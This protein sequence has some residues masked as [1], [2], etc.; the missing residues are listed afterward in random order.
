MG[1]TYLISVFAKLGITF[2]LASIFVS[3]AWNIIASLIDLLC[4]NRSNALKHIRKHRAIANFNVLGENNLLDRLKSRAL[5]NQRLNEVFKINNSFTTMDQNIHEGFVISAKSVIHSMNPHKW[6]NF[7][8]VSEA[9]LDRACGALAAQTPL[10]LAAIARFVVFVA[11]LHQFF[12]AELTG[13]T[14]FADAVEATEAINNLWERSKDTQTARPGSDAE[15]ERLQASLK[16]LLPKCFPCPPEKHPLNI[17]LPAYETMWRVV[18]L[19][20][21]SAGFRDVHPETLQQF[22]EVIQ[23]VPRCFASETASNVVGTAMNFAKEGLRLYP[24]TKRIHRAVPSAKSGSYNVKAD[25][26]WCHRNTH[27]WGPDAEQF[28]PSR[29]QG[30]TADMRQAYMPF[31]A[32][33]HQCP[34]AKTFSYH[35]IIILV[36][37]LAKRLGTV[38]TGSKVVFGNAKLDADPKELLPSGRMGMEDWTIERS[39]IDWLGRA[40]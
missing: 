33:K 17:I 28:R 34:T 12:D 26:E 40:M 39:G 1:L 22:Q 10:P 29:F 2:F 5:P 38:Q 37:V 11:M 14:D 23:N 32:G 13:N 8:A 19:T 25:V 6:A 9:A 15:Q 7:F 16:R 27:I 36:V 20:Y 18:L 24:P 21:V 31:G 35:A 30:V 4:N 3:V